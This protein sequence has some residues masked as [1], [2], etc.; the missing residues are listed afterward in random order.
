MTLAGS[1]VRLPVPLFPC[2]APW[3]LHEHWLVGTWVRHE[4]HTHMYAGSG[5]ACMYCMYCSHVYAGPLG[6]LASI[7]ACL[8]TDQSVSGT[9]E[10]WPVVAGQTMGGGSHCLLHQPCSLCHYFVLVAGQTRRGKATTGANIIIAVCCTMQRSG[11]LVPLFGLARSCQTQSTVKC[12]CSSS[13][14]CRWLNSITLYAN[15]GS[16]MR[17]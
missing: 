2:A 16:F 7:L 15:L 1:W 14:P 4:L 12:Q 5:I 13:T 6:L 17:T 11:S 10:S 9:L 8:A 3:T